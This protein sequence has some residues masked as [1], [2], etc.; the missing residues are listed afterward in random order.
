[1]TTKLAKL[2]AQVAQLTATNEALEASKSR[3]AEKLREEQRTAS[4]AQAAA[5][6]AERHAAEAARDGAKAGSGSREVDLAARVSELEAKLRAAEQA[7]GAATSTADAAG[8]RHARGLRLAQTERD[9]A[10]QDAEAA[11]AAAE[12][13]KAEVGG[14]GRST[15][16]VDRPDPQVS[17]LAML[18]ILIRSFQ[19]AKL[20]QVSERQREEVSEATSVAAQLRAAL[21][22]KGEL[23][24]RVWVWV[25]CVCRSAAPASV[26]LGT[27]AHPTAAR[28]H[29]RAAPSPHA[30]AGSLPQRSGFQSQA[31]APHPVRQQPRR[32]QPCVGASWKR[33]RRRRQRP[34]AWACR[35]R[36]CMTWRPTRMFLEHASTIGYVSVCPHTPYAYCSY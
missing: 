5:T 29:W 25:W 28:V 17:L 3:L 33:S 32:R 13:A 35:R 4:D 31:Q 21:E 7:A 2:N 36:A 20:R 14:A 27:L 10:K 30:R 12:A 8:A 11:K 9:R 22:V 15:T 23:V 19:V 34:Q 24:R 16:A 6:A 1:M 18:T 26:S